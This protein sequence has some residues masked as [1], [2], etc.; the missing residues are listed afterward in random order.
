MLGQGF[1]HSLGP[2]SC[3]WVL[4]QSCFAAQRGEASDKW[5]CLEKPAGKGGLWHGG[6]PWVARWA[7]GSWETY[8]ELYHL[9]SSWLR[10]LSLAGRHGAGQC[11]GARESQGAGI[12]W[13]T[14]A[15]CFEHKKRYKMLIITVRCLRA[16]F[17]L[18]VAIFY[19]MHYTMVKGTVIVKIQKVKFWVIQC[20]LGKIM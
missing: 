9:S 15:R 17:N 18:L 4:L 13:V 1:A 11:S 16:P 2:A 19:T 8:S 7:W 6:I 20:C 12:N 14:W 5:P 3:C 10:L